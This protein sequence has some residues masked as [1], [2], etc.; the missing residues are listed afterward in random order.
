M[1]TENAK[2]NTRI[3]LKHDTEANWLKAINF[4]P[5]AGEMIIYDA[6]DANPVR[7]K[8]GDGT[9]KVNELPFYNSNS[10]LFIEQILS[11]SQKAQ[12]RTNIDALGTPD[13]VSDEEFFM[14]LVDADIVMP[15]TSASGEIYVSNS[16]ELY[17]L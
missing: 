7:I 1:A 14:W 15:V 11:D 12:A 6:D 3:Q 13:I 9:T 2:Y 16:N 4:I 5:K 8:V 10:V 17:I